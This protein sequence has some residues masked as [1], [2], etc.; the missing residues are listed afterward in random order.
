MQQVQEAEAQITKGPTSTGE[1]AAQRSPEPRRAQP[2]ELA[3]G[4]MEPREG[5]PFSP[6][7]TD[8]DWQGWGLGAGLCA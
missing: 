7:D 6:D 2:G 3:D 8:C 5:K 1:L 4:R